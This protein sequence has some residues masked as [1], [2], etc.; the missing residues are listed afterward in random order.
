MKEKLNPIIKERGEKFKKEYRQILSAIKRYDRIAIF[1]HNTPDFDAL[2]SQLGFCYWIRDNFPDKEVIVLGDHHVSY[3]PRVFQNMD[4]VNASWF[5]KPFMAILVDV[6]NTPRISD[7]RYKKAKYK[8]RIDHH[9]KVE[10]W[11]NV[12]LIDTSFVACAEIL[13]NMFITYRRDGYTLSNR[14]S[15]MLYKGIVGDSGGFK[16]Q[17]TT[18]HTFT[19]ASELVATGLN[20]T[21]INQNMFLKEMNEIEL[22]KYALNN[23]KLSPHGVAYYIINYDLQ[24]SLKIETEQGKECLALFQNVNGIN[25]W[26]SCTED[27]TDPKYRWRV[28]VRSNTTPINEV[29]SHFNGGGHANASGAKLRKLEEL[30]VLIN[31]L[32]SLF[33]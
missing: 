15:E 24:Q 17:N 23:Y 4:R 5:E 20:V 12:V 30:D 10:S 19:I 33:K 28:S 7:P 14:V 22:K 16:Y 32:D 9:P 26:L 18:P 6:A 2:G 13:A 21:A 27:V 25:A 8:I 3:N 11:G 31:E 1:R 29:C